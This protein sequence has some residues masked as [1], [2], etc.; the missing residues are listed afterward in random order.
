MGPPYIA[1]VES[2]PMLTTNAKD[3]RLAVKL[4]RPGWLKVAATPML[5]FF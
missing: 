2:T 1:N 3:L 4:A 5:K